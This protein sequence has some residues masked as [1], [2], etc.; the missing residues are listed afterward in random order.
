MYFE[1]MLFALISVVISATCP[2]VAC[3]NYAVNNGKK[4]DCQLPSGTGCAFTYLLS[5]SMAV[6]D[7]SI[8]FPMYVGGCSGNGGGKSKPA[9]GV[10]VDV[11]TQ[12]AIVQHPA[13]VVP[14]KENDV[15]VL[16]PAVVDPPANPDQDV[17]VETKTV[18][19]TSSVVFEGTVFETI[20]AV[21]TI[22]VQSVPTRSTDGPRFAETPAS[23]ACDDYYVWWLL[24]LMI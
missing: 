15:I 11:I 22:V 16:F 20:V 5:G 10:V 1:I 9:D 14:P 6:C 21:P 3:T 24:I 23:G 13:E 18:Q 7:G 19:V 2:T 17:I 12:P 8:T 4:A